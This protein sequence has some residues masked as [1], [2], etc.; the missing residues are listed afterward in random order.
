MNGIF[1]FIVLP[2]MAILS[3]LVG[4]IYR[5]RYYGFQVSSLSS[6]FLESK[7]LYFGSRPF[8]WGIIFLF[9]G[10]LIAFLLPH[11]VLA[12]NEVPVR[13]YIL[14]ITA[15]AFGLIVLFSLVMLIIRRFKTKRLHVVTTRMDIFVYLILLVQVVTGLWTAFFFRWG[16]SWFALVLTPYLKSIFVFNPDAAAVTQLPL[17][18]QIHIISAFV[19][20]GMI[21][22][23]RFMHFLVYPFEY[24]WR[25]YQLV[26]WNF[27]KKREVK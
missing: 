27:K 15:F 14:E 6:Q 19:L 16:S 23:T 5:Y 9:F 2:Y 10:H 21:P 17:M 20:V 11:S 3:L 12:W 18:V 25:P 26:V 24:L 8:H 13:M 22:F 7:Q 4:S 1:F